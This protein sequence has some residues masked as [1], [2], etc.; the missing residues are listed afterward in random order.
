M[1]IIIIVKLVTFNTYFIR[2]MAMDL[3]NKTWKTS[4]QK[5]GVFSMRL[6]QTEFKDAVVPGDTIY[7]CLAIYYN[8]DM[9]SLTFKHVKVPVFFD[10]FLLIPGHLKKIVQRLANGNGYVVYG[11]NSVLESE[12]KSNLLMNGM[13]MV[14]MSGVEYKA[15]SDINVTVDGVLVDSE[16]YGD[17]AGLDMISE[18]EL[19]TD[20]REKK[21]SFDLL[22]KPKHVFLSVMFYLFKITY[23]KS[24]IL[25]A[26]KTF[27]EDFNKSEPIGV[28][29]F[30]ARDSKLHYPNKY[31]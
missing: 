20:S 17:S 15:L 31:F 1:K 22:R 6:V 13:A 7:V 18:T 5:G 30:S 10:R 12:A 25:K 14:E 23:N 3:I 16:E 4:F 2:F 8:V 9:Q 26:N 27:L 29:W 21:L 24:M 28:I 19:L 11:Y